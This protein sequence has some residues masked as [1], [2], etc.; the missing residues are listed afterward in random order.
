MALRTERY[1]YVEYAN[2]ERE[3]YDMRTDPHQLQNLAATADPELVAELSANLGHLRFCAGAECR[4]A[5]D[6]RLGVAASR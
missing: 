6:A 5:E 1:L 2:G 3:L 4:I